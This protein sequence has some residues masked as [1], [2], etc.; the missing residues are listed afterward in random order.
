MEKSVEQAP[1]NID[2]MN[3]GAEQESGAIVLG[4]DRSIL[5]RSNMSLANI[6]FKL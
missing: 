1:E 5:R 3:T 6:F 4:E 2:Q